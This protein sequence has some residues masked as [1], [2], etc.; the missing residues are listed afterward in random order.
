V[1]KPYCVQIAGVLKI[2]DIWLDDRLYAGQRWWQEI[3]RRLDWCEGFVYLL[4]HDSLESQ[5]CRKEF[6]LARQKGKHIFPVL[7]QPDLVLPDILRDMQYADL[8]SGLT[9][10]GVSALLNAIHLAERKSGMGGVPRRPDPRPQPTPAEPTTPSDPMAVIG[11][12]AE[13]MEAGRFDEAVFLLKRAIEQGLKPKFI[14]IFALLHEAE[15]QLEWQTEQREREREYNYIAELVKRGR[16]RKLGCEAFLNFQRDH[17]HYDP[18]NIAAIC[19]AEQAA[20]LAASTDTPIR[21]VRPSVPLLEWCEVPAGVL[22]I[23]EGKNGHSQQMKLPVE[24]FYMSKYPLTNAQFQLFADEPNGFA[25]PRWWDFSPFARSWRMENP[26][27]VP[28]QFQGDDRPREN[29]TW[30]EAMA[31]CYWL[32]DKLGMKISLPTRQQWQRAAMGD[33]GRCYPWGNDFDLSKCNTRESRIRQT[34]MVMRYPSGASPFGVQDMAG[35]VW[36]WCLNGNYEDCDVTTNAS[37]A[38]Q[39]GSYISAHERAQANFHF[40][41]S[42]EY[43]YGSIGF[44]LVCYER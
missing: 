2:H 26:G 23:V 3:M 31:Y 17:P 42:P 13:A 24:V 34:T 39:G 36:E 21:P 12:A 30:Y 10:E 32:S 4:S 43:H 38:V 5:Y 8:S 44:R 15:A 16:T 40:V 22:H 37:R 25:N 33:D 6:E 19:L 35:N 27:P 29:V 7:I 20:A 1:D 18:E 9:G 28:S 11:K 41:L 14:D